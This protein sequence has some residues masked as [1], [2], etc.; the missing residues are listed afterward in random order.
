MTSYQRDMAGLQTDGFEDNIGKVV[1]RRGKRSAPTVPTASPF[2]TEG[3]FLAS[4]IE[5]KGSSPSAE[6]AS[7]VRVGHLPGYT[8]HVPASRPYQFLEGNVQQHSH[9][10]SFFLLPDNYRMQM[11][12]YTGRNMDYCKYSALCCRGRH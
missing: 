6:A 5:P 12:G 2:G 11:P 7:V 9:E 8:G 4:I 3:P 10:K 1:R